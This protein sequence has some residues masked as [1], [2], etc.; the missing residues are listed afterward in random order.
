[1]IFPHE[2]GHFIAAKKVG[3]KVNEFAFG[4]GPAIWKKQGRETLYSIRLFPIGGFCAMEGENDE[5]DN[6][7]A[8]VNKKPWQKI[9]VLA[10]GA[11]MN[12]LCAIV[13]MIVIACALG[14]ATTT[15]ST[16]A[17]DSPAAEANIVSGDV[18]TAVNGTAIENWS[19]VGAAISSSEGKP[20]SITVERD[21]VEKTV[22]VTPEKTEA[23]YYA[24]G[25]TSKV[26]HNIGSAIINGTIGTWN[27]TKS[28]FESLGQII[29]G[30]VGAEDLSGPVGLVQMVNETTQYG[31]ISYGYLTALICINLAVINL[32]PFPALDGGRI[33]FV[34]FT[35]ITGKEVNQRIEGS[36]HFAGIVL[37]LGLMAYITFNDVTRIFG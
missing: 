1:M 26:S 21:N 20:V 19:D 10:A 14:V 22:D 11:F 17:T 9:I 25:I 35:M 12:I 3:I 8:F 36:I 2:L 34:L 6:P 13:I 4:M 31:W 33:L 7:R 15:I 16:V 5:T 27:M 28:L 37:L 29:S 32:L 24:I 18:I 30:K 23:G